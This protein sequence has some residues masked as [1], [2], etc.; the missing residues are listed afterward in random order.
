MRFAPRSP[1]AIIAG[2]AATA[3][4]AACQP[5]AT[6]ELFPMLGTS[7]R[8]GDLHV[9]GDSSKRSTVEES[10]QHDDSTSLRD[11]VVETTRTFM[12]DVITLDAARIAAGDTIAVLSTYT[13]GRT[14]AAGDSASVQFPFRIAG[15]LVAESASHGAT[16]RFIANR[17]TGTLSYSARRVGGTWQ[18]MPHTRQLMY[19]SMALSERH[20]ALTVSATDWKAI[21]GAGRPTQ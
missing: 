11:A 2:F 17:G 12:K 9:S 14:S 8:A 20:D 4:F 7:S 18:V 1:A 5:K 15:Y 21:E 16:R 6:D 19:L 13:V 3:L 10:T